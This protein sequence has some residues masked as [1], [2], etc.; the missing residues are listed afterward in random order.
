MKHILSLLT[1][2]LA[3]TA[4]TVFA[5]FNYEVV[6]D[7]YVNSYHQGTDYEYYKIRVT[8]GTGTLS[9]VDYID[10]VDSAWQSNAIS[11]KQILQYG[12]SYVN[13][14]DPNQEL[15]KV[16]A[17]PV[18]GNATA[19]EWFQVD[20]DHDVVTRY[21]YELGEFKAGDEVEIYLEMA[22]YGDAAY[23]VGS[24]TPIENR[25][26]SRYNQR[27][28]DAIALRENYNM[29]IAELTLSGWNQVM[30]GIR[31]VAKEVVVTSN[32]FVGSPLPGGLPIVLVAGFFGLGF[33]YIRRR[34]AIAA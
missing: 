9:I 8:E 23:A 29:P 14:S 3:C 10:N 31:G 34:K 1:I 5:A 11:N 20:K 21:A 26:T 6:T 27:Q 25:N 15:H 16:Y 7:K 2:A 22:N 30:F 19:V 12:Y 28:D 32:D 33:W 17:K 18:A 4:T 24:Y 13:S